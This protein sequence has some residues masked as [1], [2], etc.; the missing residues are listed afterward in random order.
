MPHV[1]HYPP[2]QVRIY[3]QWS[4]S[5]PK[6]VQELV[7]EV[8]AAVHAEC[9]CLAVMGARSVVDI[10]LTE[11]LG[12]IG[13]FEQK[14]SEAVNAGFLTTAQRQCITAAVEAGHAASH[15]GFRPNPG[16]VFDVLDIVEHA[17]RDRYVLHETSNRLGK[18]IPPRSPGGNR[19][20]A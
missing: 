19:H 11:V 6:H 14:L 4:P 8:Y 2:R 1:V 7:R 10:M 17:L 12:D 13:G 5:L 20:G 3:P 16:A 9:H 18:I 15:R